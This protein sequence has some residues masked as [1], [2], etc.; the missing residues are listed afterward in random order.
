MDRPS[1]WLLPPQDRRD[2]GKLTVVLDIDETL[3]HTT[4][5]HEKVDSLDAFAIKV[6]DEVFTVLKRPSLDLFLARAAEK[7]ELISFTA[8]VEEYSKAVL[9]EIDPKGQYFKH[10]LFRQHCAQVSPT[11]IVKDL[12][13]LNRCA[14]RMV[15]VDN[16]LSNFILQ[17]ENGVPITTF[18]DD[19]A[20]NAL[21]VLLEF[22]TCLEAAKDV[23]IPLRATFQ[24]HQL[25]KMSSPIEN[26]ENSPLS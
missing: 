11:A 26:A 3:I 7:Y 23:R 20:D 5:K 19:A 14:T 10:C 6:F 21:N 25:F 16:T 15:L 4:R 22:L 1:C 9:L 8:G 12:R 24:L 13:I 2:R 18:V 17:P